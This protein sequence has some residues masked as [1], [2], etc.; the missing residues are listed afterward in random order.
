VPYTRVVCPLYM[1]PWLGDWTWQRQKSEEWLGRRTT[2]AIR[3]WGR[4]EPRLCLHMAT[5]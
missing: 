3:G 5:W 2:Y 4:S 1:Y